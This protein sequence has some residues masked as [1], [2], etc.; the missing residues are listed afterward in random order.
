[1]RRGL[2][3][4]LALGACLTACEVPS[5]GLQILLSGGPSQK[6]ESLDCEDIPL[7]C[8]MFLS[9]RYLDPSDP[10]APFL[11][12]CTEVPLN[13]R[14]NLCAIAG[15]DV[16]VGGPLPLQDM[17]VQVA[18]FPEDMITFDPISGDPICPSDTEYDAA[19]GF[20]VAGAVTPALGGRGYYR[21]GDEAIVV[22]LGCT[23]PELLDDDVCTGMTSVRVS[24]TVDDFDTGRSVLP[25]EADRLSVGVGRPRPD[26]QGT[27]RYFLN[28]GELD[29]LQR[30][31][32]EPPAWLAEVD[33]PFTSYACLS[34]LDDTPQ[35]TS[36]VACKLATSLDDMVEFTGAP[37]GVRLAKASLDQI[38]AAL[39]LPQFPQDGITIGVVLDSDGRPL[40]NRTVTAPNS[41]VQYLSAD[42][43]TVSPT[44][45]T[46]GG[47]L[48]AVFVSQDAPFGTVFSTSGGIPVETPTA[49][50]GRLEGKVTIVILRFTGQVV[51][52]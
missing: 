11:S 15:V 45:M 44:M 23:N 46:T 30:V 20:P 13:G 1:M 51:G 33:A 37:P 52:G 34:V 16:D 10:S 38:L 5:P 4:V 36:N 6:C 24:A 18:L 31:V 35:S 9:L 12:Q 49:L 48:G 7:T 50:G 26:P 43:G 17:E 39:S 3:C 8:N 19:D 14:R 2:P 47:P 42:R 32:V 27:D 40:P 21:P 28:A 25:F 29:P 22:T 41:T